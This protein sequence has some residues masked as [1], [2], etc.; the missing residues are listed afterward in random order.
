MKTLRNILIGALVSFFALTTN[1]QNVEKNVPV[2]FNLQLK[3]MHLW[4]GYQI[5]NEAMFG[6]DLNIQDKSKSFTF[7]LW[8]GAGMTGDFKEFDYYASYEK[9]GLKFAVWDIY[10]FSKGVTHNNKEA[11]NYKAKESGHFIDVSVAYTLQGDFPLT[12]SW[13]TVVFGRDRGTTNEKN[14]YSSY[15]SANYA[16]I[17]D[18]FV[19]LDLGIAG[20]FALNPE[21]GNSSYNFYSKHSGIVNVNFV[22]SKTIDFG[23]KY[24]LPVSVM[25]MWNPANEEMNMQVALDLLRF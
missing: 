19:D 18:K 21:K 14:L 17:R 5:T 3:N 24:S 7:G 16:V 2:N 25:G 11:F 23:S 10:N 6:T 1:A 22:V 9:K 4:R 8:G 13:A 15:V 12:L 20:A